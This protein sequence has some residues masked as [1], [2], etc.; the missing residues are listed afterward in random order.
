MRED[1]QDLIEVHV[2]GACVRYRK[3]RWKLL[4]ARRTTRRS[5]F[6]G[7]WECGGGQVRKGE[8]FEGA[9][10]R[11]I[12]E[13]FGLDV[14][15]YQVLQSYEIHVRKQGIIP[16]IRY[17]CLAHEG[18]VRLNKRE[19]SRFRW[20][21]ICPVPNLDWIG[22]VKEILD[23]ISPDMLPDMTGHTTVDAVAQRQIPTPAPEKR[24]P[25]FA[26]YPSKTRVS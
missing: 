12:F 7:K 3:G 6:P 22:G 17:L 10:R 23:T 25:G 19:F 15:I 26:S 16:G 5:L 13:E 9:I 1:G 20:V 18:R 4:A 11:Q 2:A 24:R 8:G 21:N 14:Q